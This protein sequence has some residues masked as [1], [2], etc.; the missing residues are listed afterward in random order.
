MFFDEIQNAPEAIKSL[1]YFYEELPEL[2]I[3][4]AGSLLDFMIKS[5]SLSTG[6][7][8][9][10]YVYPMTF[11]E[12]L[13]VLEQIPLIE[14]I[15]HHK[16]HQPI[17]DP[18]H[19][20]ALEFFAQYLLIGGMPR[21]VKAWRDTKDPSECM[22]ALSSIVEI[23]RS[24]FGSYAKKYQKDNVKLLFESVPGGLGQRFKYSAIGGGGYTKRA[25]ES[26]LEFLDT[27]GIVNLVYHS[28]GH[29]IPLRSEI[30]RSYFKPLF[31]DVAIAQ[32]V[33]G[34]N[35][36]EWS[37]NILEEFTNKGN[38]VEAVIGQELLGYSYPHT[39]PQLFYWQ[40]QEGARQAE[41]DYLVLDDAIVP[42][43]VKSGMSARLSSMHSFLNSHEHSPYGIRFSPRNYSIKDKVYS[44]KRAYFSAGSSSKRHYKGRV[45]KSLIY[46]ERSASSSTG[47]DCV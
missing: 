34:L 5:I 4:A 15:L 25:L 43:E 29:K 28:D 24:D 16:V 13:H 39:N 22:G 36:N 41:V 40:R 2:H 18:I 3:L 8:Q 46:L 7:V 6:R 33:L 30:K 11:L 42:I 32:T 1:R 23:Y 27:A 26:A 45:N 9:L 35:I 17:T 10:L 44:Y 38:V 47:E 12:F 20:R 14:S 37:K 19:E 31:V 21:A